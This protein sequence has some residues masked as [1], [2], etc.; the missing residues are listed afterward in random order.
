MCALLF[1]P[2]LRIQNLVAVETQGGSLVE[3]VG[4]GL[5]WEEV[6]TAVEM[7]ISLPEKSK[8]QLK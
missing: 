2:G 8:L 7:C 5:I 6:G 4:G 3:G 1:T